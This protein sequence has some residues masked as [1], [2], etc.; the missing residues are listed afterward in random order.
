MSLLF[1]RRFTKLKI[2]GTK[3]KNFL[4]DNISSPSIL[5]KKYKIS[6]KITFNNPNKFKYFINPEEVLV[7]SLDLNDSKTSIPFIQ[8]INNSKINISDDDLDKK[9]IEKLYELELKEKDINISNKIYSNVTYA[10]I[11]KFKEK[12]YIKKLQTL[13][14]EQNLLNKI[15]ELENKIDFL[16]EKNNEIYKNIIKWEIKM[17]QNKYDLEDIKAENNINQNIINQFKRRQTKINNN[18]MNSLEL[19]ESQRR[20]YDNYQEK[21]NKLLNNINSYKSKIDQLKKEQNENKISIKKLKY[22]YKI[23]KN[24]LLEHYHRILFEGIDSRKEGLSWVIQAIWDLGEEVNISFMPN[25]LDHQ[26]INYLFAVAKKR[27]L[28]QKM[29][30]YIEQFKTDSSNILNNNKMYDNNRLLLSPV[31]VNTNILSLSHIKDNNKQSETLET[32]KDSKKKIKYNLFSTGINKSKYLNKYAKKILDEKNLIKIKDFIK[33][34]K[35]DEI[36]NSNTLNN[37]RALSF[38]SYIEKRINKLENKDDNSNEMKNNESLTQKR[39]LIE[40]C[41]EKFNKLIQ[42]KK[43]IKKDIDTIIDSELRRIWDEFLRNEY[44]KNYNINIKIVI[45]ALVGENNMIKEIEKQDYIVNQ[46]KI[47]KKNCYF[48]DTFENG[49][50]NSIH[51]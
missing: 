40:N 39:S 33:L 45:S 14:K 3:E 20:E 30:D 23:T 37:K 5:S 2:K 35:R 48:Y 12:I 6:N 50:I 44:E 34:K 1:K 29:K 8:I 9:R 17:N 22:E 19:F 46:N 11:K 21:K 15:K 28:L 36:N 27:I 38:N 24:D 42:L 13:E 41:M 47:L 16:Q 18:F 49:K 7:K 31:K 4:K 10:N 32:S 26:A 51:K 25:F 43:Y